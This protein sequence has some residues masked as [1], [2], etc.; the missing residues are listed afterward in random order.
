M[1]LVRNLA[2]ALLL[3]CALTVNVYA[4]DQ[5]TPGITTPPPPPPSSTTEDTTD[6]SATT[7]ETDGKVGTTDE[8]LDIL[9]D[10]IL[11]VL[12]VF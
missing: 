2:A 7:P 3:A 8:A 1:K 9:V 12:T 11:A 5:Q 6:K 4:G 10:A